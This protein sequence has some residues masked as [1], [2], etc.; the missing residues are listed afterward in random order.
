MRGEF[1]TSLRDH[2]PIRQAI[3]SHIAPTLELAILGPAI[4]VLVALP[5][6]KL[7]VQGEQ[8]G[9][10]DVAGVDAG[11]GVQVGAIARLAEAVHA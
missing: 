6:G 4:A 1:G 2:L 3:A 5:V 7:R 8:G 10:D 9:V 11:V